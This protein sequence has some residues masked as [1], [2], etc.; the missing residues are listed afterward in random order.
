MLSW[1]V[2]VVKWLEWRSVNLEVPSLNPPGS[3]AFFSPSINVLNQV[4]QGGATLLVFLLTINIYNIC[5]LGRSR[6][7]YKQNED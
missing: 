2:V 7:N 3:R 6:L 1:S 5:C 4:P